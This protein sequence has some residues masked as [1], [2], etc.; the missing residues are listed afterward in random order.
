MRLLRP[1]VKRNTFMN[2]TVR[3]AEAND[4]SGVLTLYRELRP[5]DPELT[6]DAAQEAFRGLIERADVHVVVCELG[7]TL[8]AT[9]M[10]AI[11][12]N[13]ACGAKPFGIIEHVVTLSAHRGRGY[14]RRV[15]E[16]A[17]ELAWSAQCCKVVLLSGVHRT[18]AHRLYES[19][20]FVG[21]VESGFV[22]KPKSA[23]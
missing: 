15:L 17:L 4:L 11:I 23:V 12:P 10:L 18:D 8:V 5:H 1:A 13:L 7:P 16:H 21:N 6:A 20:G 9:C 14:G 22:V 2:A 19:V 3:R